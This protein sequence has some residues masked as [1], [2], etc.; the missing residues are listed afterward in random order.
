[1]LF[2]LKSNLGIRSNGYNLNINKLRQKIRRK[3]FTIRG[4]KFLNGLL[5]KGQRKGQEI[6]LLHKGGLWKK[7]IGESLV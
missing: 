1:M 4:M 3:C 7:K 2:K 5:R 6:F